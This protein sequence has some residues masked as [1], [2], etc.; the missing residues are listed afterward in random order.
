MATSLTLKKIYPI[1]ATIDS[2]NLDYQ[3]QVEQFIEGGADLAQVRG[4]SIDDR[5]LFEQLLRIRKL[6]DRNGARFIVNN[7]VDLALA[8]GADGVHLGQQDLPVSAARKL[9]GP[10]RIIGISTHN[11]VQFEAALDEDIDYVAVGPIFESPTKPG[12]HPVLGCRYLK[13]VRSR[14]SLPIVAIGGIN[15]QNATAVWEAGADA[16]A[17]ISDLFVHQQIAA[18]VKDYLH[19]SE[20][21]LS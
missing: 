2:L 14:T 9:V 3:Q 21:L 10:D 13:E 12:S 4:T 16:V 5:E 20:E 18:R 6:C 11:R 7:R 15:L 19:H 8:A 1:T 17:V